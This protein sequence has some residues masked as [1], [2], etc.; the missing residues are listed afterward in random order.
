MLVSDWMK[1]EQIKTVMDQSSFIWDWDRCILRFH[2]FLELSFIHKMQRSSYAIKIVCVLS[3]M[4][5]VDII[6]SMDTMQY[7][8]L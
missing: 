7:Y 5:K 6:Y 4:L 2:F 3:N 8:C 1:I